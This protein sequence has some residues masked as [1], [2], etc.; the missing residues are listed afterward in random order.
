MNAFGTFSSY[1][2]LKPDESKC[3]ISVIHTLKGVSMELCRM[4]CKD[5]TKKSVKIY[6]IH[7]SYTK[8]IE[9]KENFN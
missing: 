8:K 3:K 2:A 4:G 7:F 1:S 6:S 9:N 5:L